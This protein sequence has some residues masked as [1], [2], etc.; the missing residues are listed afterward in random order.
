MSKERG[1][2]AVELALLPPLFCLL[3]FGTLD[4]ARLAKTVTE[5][6]TAAHVGVM[7]AINTYDSTG[8]QAITVAQVQQAAR[9]AVPSNL[10]VTDVT[11]LNGSGSVLASSTQV[12][13]NTTIIVRVAAKFVPLTPVVR[14]LD[15][16]YSRV[17]SSTR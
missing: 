14:N 13:A 7:T 17:R 11:V 2:S 6:N 4:L 3:L 12:P 15:Q 5:L 10:M 1:Q 8:T 9:E 16:Q